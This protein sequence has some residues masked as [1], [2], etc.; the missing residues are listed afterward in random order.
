[1]D[2]LGRAAGAAG[3]GQV[4]GR[5]VLGG[6][7]HGFGVT[8]E[9]VGED[10]DRDATAVHAPGGAGVGG[11]QLGVGLGGYAATAVGAGDRGQHLG[12]G[13]DP[14][15]RAERHQVFVRGGGGHRLPF[16]GNGEDLRPGGAQAFDPGGGA[17]F[18]ADADD[19]PVAE[20]HQAG[21]AAGRQAQPA[22]FGR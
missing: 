1:A 14:G 20:P 10:P 6:M 19:Y 11:L 22:R 4:A 21:G 2:R 9:G 7:G 18:E 13:G 16:A 3:A 5:D 17:G 15:H 12:H 8:V